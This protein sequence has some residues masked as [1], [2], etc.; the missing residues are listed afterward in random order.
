LAL[1][2][3]IAKAN[4]EVLSKWLELGRLVVIS[5]IRQADVVKSLAKAGVVLDKADLSKAVTCAK[6]QTNR[7]F[8]TLNLMYEAAPRKQVHAKRK[9]VVT[10]DI[11]RKRV[12]IGDV[13]KAH[14]KAN[15]NI[16]KIVELLA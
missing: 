6:W 11:K 7:K 9:F 14:K 3:F 4:G 5:G 2:K 8:A 16:R 12:T 15:G 10:A 13:V 1:G